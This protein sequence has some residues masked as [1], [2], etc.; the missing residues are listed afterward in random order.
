MSP[1]LTAIFLKKHHTVFSA[2][3]V[4]ATTFIL[5]AILGFLRS[6][7][8]YARF[9][10]CCILELDAYNSAF[11]IPDLIFKLLVSGALSASFI[12]VFSS[13]L[14]KNPQQ[15][16]QLASSVVNLL[17][18]CFIVITTLAAIFTKPLSGLIA[19][20]FT[21][22][23]IDLMANLSRIL[24]ISQVFFLA[25][26]FLTAILHVNAIFFIPALSQIGRAHV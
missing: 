12:P 18:L 4:L 15:A 9:F 7:F 26:N 25:S 3:V 20:G 17:S 6:R 24:L 2:S 14:K 10:N 22:A 5:S 19:S 16:H 21:P 13:A 23:Q 8:L 1:R 11:R